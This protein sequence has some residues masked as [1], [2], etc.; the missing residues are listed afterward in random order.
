MNKVFRL[1]IF[2]LIIFSCVFIT[3][4]KIDPLINEP[5]GDP[6]KP[7]RMNWS[8]R[9]YL[10][11]SQF[12]SEYGIGG[13]YYDPQKPPYVVIDWDNT[14]IIF[15]TEEAVF[16]YQVAN[17]LFKMTKE[18]FGSILKNEINGI[19]RLSPDYNNVSLSD[20]N[21]DL[22]K[23]YNYIFD[24]Y[25][26]IGGTMT[27]DEIKETSEYKDFRAR[28]AFL[29]SGYC[30]TPGIEAKYGYP[31]V[32]YLFAGYTTEEVKA[33]TDKVITFELENQLSS[34]TWESPKDL[35]TQSGYISHSFKAGLR[36]IPE[37]Q[38][39]LST[40]KANGI[41]VFIVSA[42]FKP[43]IEVFAGR[44]IY[45]YNIA[46]EKV[47]AM[48]LET[49]TAGV[50]LPNYKPGW[51][52]TQR[53]GKVDAINA[54]IKD[55]QG[56][57]WDPIF[58]AADSDGDYE[59]STKFPGMRLTLIWNRVKGG[60]IGELCKQAV[61]EMQIQNPRYTLQGRNE[62]TGKV[63]PYSESILFGKTELQLLK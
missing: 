15:D 5:D 62:N 56:I 9:N 61:A 25:S 32:L 26:G 46:P 17:L 28:L 49:T 3:C 12:I 4:G 37:M 36:I 51:Y 24:N 1:R 55:A 63:I 40:F 48:E 42:S 11:L 13:K 2:L 7:D 14:C 52:I 22:I 16:H 60:K 18:E 20:I 30:D 57:T 41:D 44:E 54:V 8:E 21:A 10:I 31:W 35:A 50:I 27:L 47:I 33:L 23:S 6:K 43:V 45:G 59:M 53:E 38:N 58:S 29:Y 39:L 19:S 34:Q